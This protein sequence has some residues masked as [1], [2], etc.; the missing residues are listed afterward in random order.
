MPSQCFPT[1]STTVL[2]APTQALNDLA[3][4][5]PLVALF[6]NENTT[7]AGLISGLVSTL[8]PNPKARLSCI[9][10]AVENLPSIQM[11]FSTTRGFSV[12]A[13]LP[14]AKHLLE[15]RSAAHASACMRGR[16]RAYVMT[17][18]L[19]ARVLLWPLWG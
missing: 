2:L 13:V 19:E 7:F 1:F 3:N 16:I 15:T 17:Y 4:A 18:P 14:Y 12:D 5:V 10:K 8:G 11:W 9:R 6:A